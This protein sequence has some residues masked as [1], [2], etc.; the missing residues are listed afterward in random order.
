MLIV[1]NFIISYDFGD[2]RMQLSEDFS[3]HLYSYPTII[4]ELRSTL[5]EQ[6][7]RLTIQLGLMLSGIMGVGLAV[8]RLM[9]TS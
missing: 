1:T 7:L 8:T 3:Y 2:D 4:S 9:L 5:R 6:G